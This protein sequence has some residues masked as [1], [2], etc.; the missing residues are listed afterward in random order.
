MMNVFRDS[1]VKLALLALYL[2]AALCL[3]LAHAE[4]VFA[5]PV[6]DRTSFCLGAAGDHDASGLSDCSVCCVASGLEAASFSSVN[7]PLLGLDL[8]LALRSTPWVQTKASAYPV[9]SRAPPKVS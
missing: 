8:V 5:D 4:P 1:Q 6:L 9:G 3:S 2:L 7:Q